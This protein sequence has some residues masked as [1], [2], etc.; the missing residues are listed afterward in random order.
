VKPLTIVAVVISPV[1]AFYWFGL[2]LCL[3]A[4]RYVPQLRD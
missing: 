1:L 4:E 2:L 3:L